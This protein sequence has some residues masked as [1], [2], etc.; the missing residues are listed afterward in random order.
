[1]TMAKGSY[2]KSKKQRQLISE[3]LKG[4]KP[5]NKKDDPEWLLFKKSVYEK[6]EAAGFRVDEEKLKNFDLVEF[7]RPKGY[8][9]K[10]FKKLI[11]DN[12]WNISDIIRFWFICQQGIEDAS[13]YKAPEWHRWVYGGRKNPLHSIKPRD[14]DNF[15]KRI[16]L[17]C[18]LDEEEL[19][20]RM[21]KIKM[22]LKE[23]NFDDDLSNKKVIKKDFLVGIPYEN[24]IPVEKDI[25]RES[26]LWQPSEKML[27]GIL[28]GKSTIKD[29]YPENFVPKVVAERLKKLR[30][31]MKKGGEKL[32]R[33]T[34]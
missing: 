28:E 3:S 17:I 6:V 21:E 32:C 4:R 29:F 14:N 16:E 8:S 12:N 19:K 15:F 34:I 22:E 18:D 26:Y 9:S 11:A 10:E 30:K 20:K 1:M 24:K 27:K 25:P 31:K 33:I 7:Y 23:I 5:W 2:K 13:T